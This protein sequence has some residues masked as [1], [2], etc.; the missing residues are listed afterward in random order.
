M[1]GSRNI[2]RR[3]ILIHGGI[4]AAGLALLPS[5]VLAQLARLGQDET[6]APWSDDLSRPLNPDF[7]L[8]LIHKQFAR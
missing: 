2:S 5:H 7:P 6:P 3:D 8:L 4:T 1:S